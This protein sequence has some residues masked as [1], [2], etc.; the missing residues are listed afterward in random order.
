MAACAQCGTEVALPYQCKYC[1]GYFCPDHRLPENHACSRLPKRGWGAKLGVKKSEQ[2]MRKVRLSSGR[3]VDFDRNRITNDILRSVKNQ[4]AAEEL[5]DKVVEDLEQ[6]Y[7]GRI[8]T[9]RN[10]HYAVKKVLSEYHKQPKISGSK[11]FSSIVRL[12]KRK[13]VIIFLAFLVMTSIWTVT[14]SNSS[15]AARLAYQWFLILASVVFTCF[16]VLGFALVVMPKRRWATVGRTVTRT[17]GRWGKVSGG[18]ESVSVSQIPVER[19][20]LYKSKRFVKWS[21]IIGSVL[22]LFGFPYGIMWPEICSVSVII[23]GMCLGMGVAL[24]ISGGRY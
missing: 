16:F 19:P 3:I 4:N 10:I 8:P 5:S 6:R 17:R 22:V 13:T 14:Y 9:T 12:L 7:A 2:A 23:G 15:F 21:L 20:P 24:V 18:E 11:K 1:G